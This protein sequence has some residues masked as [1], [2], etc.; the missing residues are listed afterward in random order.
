M[1]VFWYCCVDAR[2][3][4]YYISKRRPKT[5]RVGQGKY[6]IIAVEFQL[7]GYQQAKKWVHSRLAW[8]CYSTR[9]F[10]VYI[11]SIGVVVCIIWWWISMPRIRLKTLNVLFNFVIPLHPFVYFFF[12]INS[13][14]LQAKRL[15][16]KIPRMMT[17]RAA[18]LTGLL[19]TM[20]QK[21]TGFVI[22]AVLKMASLA[23]DTGG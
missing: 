7:I 6:S 16:I 8:W 3:F 4:V 10:E 19:K 9:R 22:N 13:I 17:I 14:L 15:L 5:H 2:L 11:S 12:K 1:C 23:L 20:Y 18:H 21:W